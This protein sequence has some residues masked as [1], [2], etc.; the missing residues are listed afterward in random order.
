MVA[1]Q[2]A[3]WDAKFEVEYFQ[4]LAF[5]TTDVPFTENA[6]AKSPMNVLESG[7][8]QILPEELE[9]DQVDDKTMKERTYLWRHNNRTKKNSLQSP[10]L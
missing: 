3:F 10:L 5:D 4:I 2:V 7:V 9:W 6:S 8:V 1:Q